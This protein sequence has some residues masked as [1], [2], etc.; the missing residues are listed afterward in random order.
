M[1]KVPAAIIRKL[2]T[3]NAS[4]SRGCKAMMLNGMRRAVASE[5]VQKFI[6]APNTV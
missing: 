1:I 3:P 4:Y 2:L 6:V 5:D